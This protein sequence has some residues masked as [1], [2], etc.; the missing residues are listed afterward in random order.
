MADKMI[1]LA[2]LDQFLSVIGLIR[3]NRKYRNART[4]TGLYALYTALTE[5]KLYLGS[6]DNGGQ[7]GK[8]REMAL[9]RLWYDASVPLRDIDPDLAERCFDKG[10]YWTNPDIWSDQMLEEKNIKLEQ[11]IESIRLLLLEA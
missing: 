7:R 6:L 4:D 5:T 2:L 11:V 8:K 1:A 3:E 10:A 9:A